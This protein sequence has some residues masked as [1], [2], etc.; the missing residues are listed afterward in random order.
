MAP[1][2]AALARP[3]RPHPRIPALRLRRGATRWQGLWRGDGQTFPART[4]P[5]R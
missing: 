3:Q 1:M 5:K 4:D 2:H